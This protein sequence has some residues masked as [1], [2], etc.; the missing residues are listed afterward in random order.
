MVGRAISSGIVVIAPGGRV[1]VGKVANDYGDYKWSFAKGRVEAGLSLEEN[2]PKE[3]QEEM[4][5]E[6]RIVGD[7]GDYRGDTGT[8]HFFLGEVTGG[9]PADFGPETDEVRL[10]TREEAR[11][12]L[13][14]KRDHLVLDELN[15]QRPGG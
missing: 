3:L 5:L 4:G 1:Y 8:T 2:A 13:N 14:K 12:L 15:R 9:D 6:A 11:K 10:V 7:L